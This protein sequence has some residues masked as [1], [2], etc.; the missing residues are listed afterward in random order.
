MKK[1][2]GYI[3]SRP[4]MGERAPQHVQNIVIKDFC[5]NNSFEYLLSVSEYKM[6]NSFLMLNDLIKKMKN[7]DGI[8]AYSIFQLPQDYKNR[9]IV[10]KK[11]LKNKKFISFAVEKI[12]VSKLKD[13]KN[14]N[15]LW[16]IK[17]NLS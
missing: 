5:Y 1:I 8:V 12:T 15:V 6:E 13:I 16:R 10:L 4:F 7:I 2:R 17:K 3:F 9:N 14:I 11:I